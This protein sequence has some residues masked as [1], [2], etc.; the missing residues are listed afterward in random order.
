MKR[1]YYL[2]E[3]LDELAQVERELEDAGIDT[4]QIHVLS[5]DEAGIDKRRM[6]RVQDF[7]RRDVVRTTLIGAGIG[8]VIASLILLI[9]YFSGIIDTVTW[10][11]FLLFALIALGFCAWEGGLY[12][13][14]QP[15]HKLK[16]IEAFAKEGQHVLFV[17]M[18]PQEIPVLRR[19][20]ARHASLTPAGEGEAT[21]GMAIYF[22]KKWHEFFRAAP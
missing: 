3:S 19:V 4:T 9:A 15:H 16:N 8:V 21:P 10:A 22:Q 7:M 12:G 11:P 20:Q 5:R 2:S 6:H 13:L 14:H 1:F 17:D 18:E